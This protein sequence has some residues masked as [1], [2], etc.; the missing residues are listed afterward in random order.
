MVS[1]FFLV[2]GLF[3]LEILKLLLMEIIVLL[4]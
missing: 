3:L 1:Y 4:L 2:L